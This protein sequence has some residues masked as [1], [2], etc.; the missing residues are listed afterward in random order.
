MSTFNYFT[1]ATTS[2]INCNCIE[3]LTQFQEYSLYH[4]NIINK[5]IHFIT[6]PIIMVTTAHVLEKF[7]L[8]YDEEKLVNTF[9]TLEVELAINLLSIVQF[10][11]GIYYFTWSWAIGFSMIIY[12]ELIIQAKDKLQKYLLKKTKGNFNKVCMIDSIMIL[13]MICAWSLQF[14]GH[15]I[16]GS[17]PALIDNLSAAFLTAPMFTL[18]FLFQLT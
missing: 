16:E 15:Y 13:I 11:Y 1:N 3:P 9:P 5:I 14:L 8:V 2:S 6:I 18:N 10:V 4:T 12:F 17:R 7:H